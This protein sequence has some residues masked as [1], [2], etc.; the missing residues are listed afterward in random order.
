ME[1]S[2]FISLNALELL[3]LIGL[4][5]NWRMT[6]TKTM[7]F[8]SWS[9]I[10]TLWVGILWNAE[11]DGYLCCHYDNQMAFSKGSWKRTHILYHLFIFCLQVSSCVSSI[12]FGR[13]VFNIWLQI[14]CYKIKGGTPKSNFRRP[15]FTRPSKESN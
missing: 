11:N 14:L 12:C 3:G 8:C 4:P 15:K 6:K 5:R 1:N 9:C 10:L 13:T 7:G 2:D